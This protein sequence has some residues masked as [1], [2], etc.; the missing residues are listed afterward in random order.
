[1]SHQLQAGIDALITF[2]QLGVPFFS[3]LSELLASPDV[4]PRSKVAL[5]ACLLPPIIHSEQALKKSALDVL[6]ILLRKHDGSLNFLSLVCDLLEGIGSKDIA[7][8]FVPSILSIAR[9][10]QVPTHSDV[11]TSLL[12]NSDKIYL[13]EFVDREA[14][15]DDQLTYGDVLEETSRAVE[16]F[17][18][19]YDIR[20][21]NDH[22]DE[23]RRVSARAVG[24][25]VDVMY[26]AFREELTLRQQG[27]EEKTWRMAEKEMRCF[28]C[29][30]RA[31]NRCAG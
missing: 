11:D 26:N 23:A 8:L 25:P 30:G 12:Q 21:Q 2:S 6:A 17:A 9:K 10:L 1:M 16:T 3:A 18:L 31:H 20:L 4:L 28:E 14:G 7:L 27:K 22:E 24:A 5:L 29:E 19:K 13:D 15:P